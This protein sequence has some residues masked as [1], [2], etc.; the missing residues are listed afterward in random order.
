MSDAGRVSLVGA[1]PGDPGLLTL[2]AARAIGTAEVL[3]YDAL[4]SDAIVALAQ[5]GCEKIYV[6]KRGGNHAMPQEQIEALMVEKARS[7]K[8]VKE[9]L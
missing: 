4:A 3:L 9:M 8:L 2:R 6:G 7:G 1:G 5:P